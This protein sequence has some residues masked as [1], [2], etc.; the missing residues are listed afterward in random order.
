MNVG[1]LT[2]LLG[3][4]TA[5]LSRA[6]VNVKRF[7]RQVVNSAN[8]MSLAF[9]RLSSTMALAGSMLGMYLSAP[10]GLFGFAATKMFGDFEFGLSRIVG[11]VGIASEQT[12]IWG[13][14][15]LNIAGRQMKGPQEL[16]DTLYF[17]TSGGIRGAESMDIL[18]KAAFAAS[19]GLGEAATIANAVTS[20]M[21]AYGKAN[22]SAAE[23]FDILVA[24]IREGKVE[25]EKFTNAIG[26]VLPF[27]AALKV[28]FNEVG[29][30]MAGMTR[31]GTPEG[32]A[33]MQ[34]R[35]IFA[36][37][38]SQKPA[39]EAA[40]NAVGTSFEKLL[41][42]IKSEGLI[43]G[44]LEIRRLIGMNE[45]AL[46]D[47]FPNL[48]E[49][50]G[51]LDLMG[52]NLNE[53]KTL[54]EA[55]LHPIGSYNR[56]IKAAS[57][58]FKFQFMTAVNQM[59]VALITF[60]QSIAVAILPIMKSFAKW[61]SKVATNFSQLT[62]AQKKTRVAFG[63]ML[64]VAGPLLLIL[65][66]I[67]LAV[68]TL[69]IALKST[70]LN[71]VTL[72]AI[73]IIGLSMSFK[74]FMDSLENT[75]YRIAKFWLQAK[76]DYM[77]G[78][79]WI[80]DIMRKFVLLVN[81]FLP[82]GWGFDLPG[83]NIETEKI[84]EQIKSL[85]ELISLLD[86]SIAKT[87]SF[88]DEFKKKWDPVFSKISDYV[89]GK[90]AGLTDNLFPGG[91][92]GINISDALEVDR[93]RLHEHTLDMNNTIEDIIRNILKLRKHPI[94]MDINMTPLQRMLSVTSDRL[95]AV[96]QRTKD[97]GIEF[98]VLGTKIGILHTL[99]EKLKTMKLGVVTSENLKEIR[100]LLDYLKQLENQLGTINDEMKLS[101]LKARMDIL[102]GG[103]GLMD[104]QL[105]L[106]KKSLRKLI[107]MG[108]KAWDTSSIK[109]WKESVKDASKEI[110]KL[111][112]WLKVVDSLK[113]AMGQLFTGLGEA[114]GRSMAGV[115]NAWNGMII[116][117]L[118][119]VKQIGSTLIAV[120]SIML[121]FGIPGG[122]WYIGAGIALVA[123]STYG[124][125]KYQQNQEKKENPLVRL[126]EGGIVPSGYKNDTY[127]AM[128]SSN[129]AV[130]PLERLGSL[131]NIN[132]R[133]SQRE[134]IL[135]IEGRELVGILVEMDKFN[136]AF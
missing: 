67:I 17:I 13:N 75:Q 81:S 10:L 18:E 128:L 98:D 62:N 132:S 14:E 111:E 127:P 23:T 86:F 61:L 31:T 79:G 71:S 28:S 106:M 38:I 85:Q 69:A 88:G 103:F 73:A 55:M 72:V 20:V 4:N 133:D 113:Q 118:D 121:G 80:S 47:V 45:K 95:V 97:L 3:V 63:L 25:P 131:I 11:L 135:K 136:N 64:F 77:Q 29:A 40:L 58:T 56:L 36:A 60:G 116:T 102:G 48:R 108:P 134:I 120:G 27:A 91:M 114:L 107:D 21:N 100:Q 104:K 93:R 94:D 89:K 49:L 2:V 84:K 90:I 16:V 42:V 68:R 129:E 57:G 32:T 123:L 126:A 83:E 82:T 105:Q 26:K 65:G 41:R 5:G 6:A 101:D 51:I 19:A 46:G 24:A 109:I 59:K 130:I 125:I 54:W 53:N 33:A 122:L 44:L 37:F 70:L 9:K 39:A 92:G 1:T 96:D 117:L 34:L 7:E 12:K 78:T 87:P 66:Q 50:I 8:R 22:I 15:L 52:E 76:L 30:A 124:S 35:R 74:P 119:V 115:E 43:S 99:F 112:A 110:I